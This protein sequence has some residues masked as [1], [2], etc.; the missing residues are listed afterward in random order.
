MIQ[1]AAGGDNDKDEPR[2]KEVVL[3]LEIN[4]GRLAS[5][6]WQELVRFMLL[7]TLE[8]WMLGKHLT[9]LLE[10][11]NSREGEG[12]QLKRVYIGAT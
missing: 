6:C 2:L 4:P 10:R 11:E 8:W 3:K 9:L 12:T 5:V 1:P 7:L